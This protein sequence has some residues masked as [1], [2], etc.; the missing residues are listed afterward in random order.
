[1][2]SN[3]I[4]SS[5]RLQY[6][7]HLTHAQWQWRDACRFD[8]VQLKARHLN[9]NTKPTQHLAG[10]DRDGQPALTLPEARRMIG[11]Q[12]DWQMRATGWIRNSGCQDL[13]IFKHISAYR[14][15]SSLIVP[16]PRLASTL[17]EGK[18]L[19]SE[20]RLVQKL[21]LPNSF[22]FDLDVQFSQ[23][24]AQVDSS[25]LQTEMAASV[26]QFLQF[27]CLDVLIWFGTQK[28]LWQSLVTIV[29]CGMSLPADIFWYALAISSWG[30]ILMAMGPWTRK[31]PLAWSR[32]SWLIYVWSWWYCWSCS[33][34]CTVLMKI[35]H[36]QRKHL[37]LPRA[38]DQSHK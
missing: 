9:T 25:R 30:L 28:L 23:S 35:D 8:M 17:R 15:C 20:L 13:S 11:A 36:K 3:D 34:S 31:R 16:W 24:N 38:D 18:S 27:C 1:M 6:T 7:T 19:S 29:Q 37:V 12:L 14:H 32:D 4:I 22:F 5:H 33:M 21:N 26:W 2:R 10:R